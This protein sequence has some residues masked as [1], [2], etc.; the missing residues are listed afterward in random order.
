MTGHGEK[1][2][3]TRTGGCGGRQEKMLTEHS[4][5]SI[6]TLKIS[7]FVQTRLFLL[8]VERHLGTLEGIVAEWMGN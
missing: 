2:S 6:A 8:N 1:P 4:P 5:C 7:I 3:R